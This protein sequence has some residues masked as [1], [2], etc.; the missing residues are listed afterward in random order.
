MDILYH[1]VFFTISQIASDISP[2]TLGRATTVK[3][4]EA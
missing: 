4:R 3:K 2:I 1:V